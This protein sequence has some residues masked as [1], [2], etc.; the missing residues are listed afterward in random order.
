MYTRDVYGS[1]IFRTV[2]VRLEIPE[3]NLFE[4]GSAGSD[5]SN[6]LDSSN[7]SDSSDH[8]HRSRQQNR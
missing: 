2:R 6:N 8:S 3:S 5:G 4:A 1:E 7:C